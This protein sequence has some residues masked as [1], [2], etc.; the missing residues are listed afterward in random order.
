VTC[1]GFVRRR[2]VSVA[3]RFLVAG[4][5]AAALRTGPPTVIWLKNASCFG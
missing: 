2:V 4:G 5:M 1:A 3:V